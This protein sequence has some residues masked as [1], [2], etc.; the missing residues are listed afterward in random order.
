MRDAARVRVGPMKAC[1]N[2]GELATCGGALTCE[3]HGGPADLRQ[4]CGS[5]LVD[6]R[7]TPRGAARLPANISLKNVSGT[8]S[9]GFLQML[10]LW[11]IAM[12]SSRIKCHGVGF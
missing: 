4:V 8:F 11:K 12:I 6:A 9:T 7:P 1:S 10:L 3:E 2:E 5:C